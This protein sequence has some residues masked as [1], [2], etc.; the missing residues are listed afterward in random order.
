MSDS[1]LA[2]VVGQFAP[3]QWENVATEALAFLLRHPGVDDALRP[4]LAPLG[5]E[6]GQKLEWR[7][8]AVDPG[9][10][11]R[12]DLV[13]N[14]ALGR[15]VVIV[16]A[17]FWAALTDNQPVTYLERQSAQ[18]AGEAAS[19]LLLFLVP[20]ARVDLVV[21]ELRTRLP[22]ATL[23]RTELPVLEHQHLGRTVIL[24][25]QQLLA[26][27]EV[28]LRQHGDARLLEDLAQLRGLTD[29]ADQEAMLPLQPGDVDP[30]RDRRYLQFC[31]VVDAVTDRLVSE[32]LVSTKGLRAT[33]GKGWYAR[34]VKAGSHEFGLFVHAS[35][36][37][38]DYPSPWWL[39]FWNVKPAVATA[40][41]E[42]S[43]GDVLPYVE[44]SG[45]HLYVALTPPLRTDGATVVEHLASAV[46]DI[47]AGLPSA[48][49]SGHP[50]DHAG[51]DP[52]SVMPREAR[53]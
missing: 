7:T 30:D 37:S 52:N 20:Q 40:V 31:D 36:W 35:W 50:Q 10:E 27:I 48:T 26:A 6:A 13:G 34:Y 49:S 1:L 33:G 16:E 42:L 43:K 53:E 21:S 23:S 4:L 25:W 51:V 2:H 11:G 45:G 24:S 44:L 18:F 38:R 32:D 28:T 17:K 47:I 5:F 39:R 9:D 3:R 12:P 46:R 14:D 15:H 19:P 8:Q 29:R 22:G 41:Q